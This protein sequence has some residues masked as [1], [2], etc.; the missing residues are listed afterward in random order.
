[1]KKT[2]PPVL[3][4]SYSNASDEHKQWAIEFSQ[5]LREEHGVD[6]TLD[7]R[8]FPLSDYPSDPSGLYEAAFRL[9]RT[10]DFPIWNRL[11]EKKKAEFYELLHAWREN[12]QRPL[13]EVNEEEIIEINTDGLKVLEPLFAVALAGVES[14]LDRF[15]RQEGIVHDLLAPPS[16]GKSGYLTVLVNFPETAVF[17]FQALLGAFAVYISQPQLVFDL[18]NQRAQHKHQNKGALLWKI[19]EFIGWP[20]SLNGNC[21]D[22]WHFLWELPKHMPWVAEKLSGE[23]RFRQCLCGHYF[24]LSFV[25]LVDCVRDQSQLSDEKSCRFSIPPFFIDKDEFWAGLWDI[26]KEKKQL[27]EYIRVKGVSQSVLIES[28]PKWVERYEMFLKSGSTG[29]FEL[30][31]D[32]YKHIMEDLLT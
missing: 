1:M 29:F 18:A 7:Q 26:H 4:I 27:I 31:K 17:V 2:T 13:N 25:E 11:I 20:S 3:F 5:K 21:G 30:G 23:R 6:V 12:H 32:N 15:N 9:A 22:A 8:I 19:N 24:L 16:W 10:E 28:W 14:G